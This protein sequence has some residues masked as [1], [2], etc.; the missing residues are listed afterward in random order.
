MTASGRLVDDLASHLRQRIV[1]GAL[2]GGAKLTEQGVASEYSVARP[3]VRSAVDQLARDGLVF[4][5]PHLPPQ[6]VEVPHEEIPEILSLLETIERLALENLAQRP[7]AAR[8]VHSVV[9]GSLHNALGS[10]VTELGSDRLAALHRRLTFELI[11]G[12]RDLSAPFDEASSPAAEIDVVESMGEAILR[13]DFWGVRSGALALQ[14]LRRARIV[15]PVSA[16]K[17]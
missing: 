6:V 4:R 2:R 15:I 3:T 5:Q 8:A 10:M 17:P 14:A 1:S 7:H 9:G 11:L 12:S 13:E 16:R